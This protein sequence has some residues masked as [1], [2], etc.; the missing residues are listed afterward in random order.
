MIVALPMQSY[1]GYP[2]FI[3]NNLLLFQMII[4]E[5][6]NMVMIVKSKTMS[7]DLSHQHKRENCADLI[8]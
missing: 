6:W 7:L 4:T 3:K 8:K 1:Y 5:F 2:E